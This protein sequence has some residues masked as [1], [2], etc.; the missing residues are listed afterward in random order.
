MKLSDRA[1]SAA[2][3][4]ACLAALLSGANRL[5]AS[6][7]PDSVLG[8]GLT[9][10]YHITK[11]TGP[12]RPVDLTPF[13]G[14]F[15]TE[16][17]ASPTTGLA[18]EIV[19]YTRLAPGAPKRGL[20]TLPADHTY[21]VMKG[22]INVQIGSDEF[23]VGP[24]TLILVHS[25]IPAQVW[26]A[27]AEQADVFEAI[28]PTASSDLV[29]L[30]RPARAT[31]VDNPAQYIFLAPDLGPMKGGVGHDSLNERI[32]ASTDNGSMHIHERLDDV[33]PGGGSAPTHT[34]EGDQVYLV[35]AGTMTVEY[36][37]Q[38]F[39]AGL[40]TLV[41]LLRG[42]P[43]ANANQGSTVESH[44]TLLMPAPPDGGSRGI[45]AMSLASKLAGEAK[46]KQ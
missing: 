19:M 17:L 35:T 34:H 15:S 22:K 1:K 33:L 2:L 28:A 27:G 8:T 29:S 11:S 3:V 24:N 39:P 9:A 43:H 23:A 36:K 26:N 42:V 46:P 38:K 13:Q 7:T 44:V 30:M 45:P 12:L 16:I 20:Y 6:G 10:G 25:G 41:I 21:L 40:N 18:A 14:K 32:M 31:K 4:V 37:G 5:Y